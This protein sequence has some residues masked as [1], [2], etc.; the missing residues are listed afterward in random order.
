MPHSKW[1]GKHRDVRGLLP[2]YIS[3][4]VMNSCIPHYANEFL[5]L[6]L[7]TF[8]G[9]SVAEPV[10]STQRHGCIEHRCAS[11]GKGV[12]PHSRVHVVERCTNRLTGSFRSKQVLTAFR[13]VSPPMDV[14]VSLSG[15]RGIGIP[16]R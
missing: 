2:T 12:T 15:S 10:Q 14:V 1:A 13:E 5:Q 9:E 6:S 7:R 8:D 4:D 16:G 3:S 11:N